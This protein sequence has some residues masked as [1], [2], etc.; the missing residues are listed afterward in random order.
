MKAL[1]ILFLILASLLGANSYAQQ[2]AAT[3]TPTTLDL[4]DGDTFVFLG[5]SITHQCLYTQYIEDFFYTRFPERKIH[6]HNAGVSG[7][8]AADAL[9]RFDEDTAKFKAKYVSILLGMNDGHYEDFST[10][11]F[12]AYTAGMKDIISRIRE[13]G[14]IPI[15]LSPTMFDHHQL[16]LMKKNNPKFRF[17]SRPFSRQYNSLMAFYSAW[18]RETAGAGNIPFINLWGPLNDFTFT[19][20]RKNPDFSLVEDTIHPGG[21]GQFIMAYSMLWQLPPT[22]RNVSN[23]TITK[24]GQKW[25]GTKGVTNLVVSENADQVSFAFLASSLPWVVPGGLS[26]YET[27]RGETTP[28]SL[29]Y[30]L[31]K[32]GHRLSNERFRVAGLAPGSYELSIDGKPV[33]KYTHLQ[34]G[35]KIELQ[36]NTKTPQYQQAMDVAL[37]NRER[38]D[39]AVRPMRD[40]WGRIK[41]LRSKGDQALFDKAYPGLLQK[42]KELQATAAEYESRIYEAAQPKS[43]KYQLKR[44]KP[45]SKQG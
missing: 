12:A 34:L 41:G 36:A 20:R 18:L 1:R 17:G 4:Q 43:R 33:G 16:A 29:G 2:K 25:K 37:L 7:D 15:A 13:N 23:I 45:K 22:Q 44:V 30:Q 9:A 19:E 38:N 3:Q 21:A 26:D 6:F 31:T 32:A 39:T 8:Q 14:A 11:T 42:I 10:E 28:A 24:A 27:K 40:N 5:D 35:A